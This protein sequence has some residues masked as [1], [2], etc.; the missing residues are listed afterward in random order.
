MPTGLP[1]VRSES[2][3]ERYAA[4]HAVPVQPGAPPPAPIEVARASQVMRSTNTLDVF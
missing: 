1:H 2:S 3:G 4:S